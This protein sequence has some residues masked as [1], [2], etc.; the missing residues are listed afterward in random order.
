MLEKFKI[1][2]SNPKVIVS[3]VS[4]VLMVLVNM[5]VIDVAMS[6]KVLEIVNIV[7]PILVGIGVFGDPE[8]HVKEEGYK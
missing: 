8:S 7:L 4:M 3:M 1:R 6:D 2:I 5:R